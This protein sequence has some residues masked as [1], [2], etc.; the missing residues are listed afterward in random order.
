MNRPYISAKVRRQVA[1]AARYRCEYCQIQQIVIGIPLHI[2]HIIPLVV[3]GTS[4]ESNL[5]LACSVCNNYSAN[6][7]FNAAIEGLA[8]DNPWSPPMPDLTDFREA[9]LTGLL[10]TSLSQQ[11]TRQQAEYQSQHQYTQKYQHHHI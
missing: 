10:S 1:E 2:E 8:V 6:D 4:D 7:R 11:P 5:W 3:E 9:C